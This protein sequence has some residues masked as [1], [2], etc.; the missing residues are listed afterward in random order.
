MAKTPR[1]KP[2]SK[3]RYTAADHAQFKKDLLANDEA[4]QVLAAWLKARGWIVEDVKPTTVAERPEDWAKHSDSGDV[5]AS[6]DA[7]PRT[8]FEVKQRTINFTGPHDFPFPDVVICRCSGFDRAVAK[9]GFI[10][11]FNQ[12]RTHALVIDCSRR[13]EWRKE[14]K[15]DTRHEDL[16]QEFYVTDIAACSFQEVPYQF[17]KAAA[18]AREREAAA[19]AACKAY[20]PDPKNWNREPTDAP[21]KKE[22]VTCKLCGR[23][24]GYTE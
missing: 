11:L 2:A 18:A 17:C 3:P 21:G 5:W 4:R 24:I 10:V 1:K 7:G 9:P 14:S 6:K 13:A 16:T 19:A 8:R 22:R 20:H 23:F 12:P 15:R